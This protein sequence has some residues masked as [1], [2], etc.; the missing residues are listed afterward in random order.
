MSLTGITS[1]GVYLPRRRLQ[2]S[3]V[4]GANRW[5]NPNLGGKGTKAICAQDED[6]LTLAVAAGRH[7]LSHN[8]G[9][10]IESVL[11]ASCSMPF[12]DRQNATLISEALSLGDS[13]QTADIGGSSRAATTALI[14]ALRSGQHSLVT[15]AERRV[16][17]PGSAQEL[18]AGD[19]AAALIVGE[20]QPLAT[21][22]DSHSLAVDFVDHYQSSGASFG[23][24]LEE[25]WVRDEGHLKILP[26]AI[27][28]LL[29]KSGTPGCDIRHAVLGI[30]S[31]RTAHSIATSCG[32]P[33]AS[34]CEDVQDRC[35]HTGSAHTLL[36]LCHV[37]QQAKPGE[38]ILV[39]GFGQGCDVLLLQA[40]DD[41]HLAR[42]HHGLDA[43][44]AEGTEDGNY[45]RYL[46]FT[47]SVQ[48]DWGMRAER[49]NRTSQSAFYRH[50]GTVTHFI[51]GRCSRCG[52]KQFPKSR[53]CANPECG[54]IDTQTD[55]PFRYKAAT[56][57]S[58]T[59]D[60]LALSYNPPLMY[61]NVS[62]EGGGVVM[63]EFT[64]FDPGE[65]RVGLPLSMQFRIK[66]HDTKRHFRRYCWKAAPLV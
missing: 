4:V 14:M 54:A 34:L 43:A 59:E 19:G 44:L 57:K 52:T 12:A 29:E 6:S 60:W 49:D 32:I 30:S 55:E 35:G 5:A 13:L 26:R 37:L 41:I 50:R 33:E 2:R 28:T 47:G 20:E 48:M 38:L 7:A 63:M 31:S 56:I 36:M 39:A 25:R 65:L 21:L 18:I 42:R 11:F 17:P 24:Y 51:G 15:A 9:N 64:D 46:S 66:D 8:G 40:T 58:F 45:L 16:M 10:G 22:I 62:F 23:Y 27:T 1:L 3:A 53:A 61:G